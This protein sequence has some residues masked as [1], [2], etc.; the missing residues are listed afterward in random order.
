MTLPFPLLGDDA[1]VSITGDLSEF[2]L[3]HNGEDLTPEVLNLHKKDPAAYVL[4][5]Y[6]QYRDSIE[7]LVTVL[8]YDISES[9]DTKILPDD[10]EQRKFEKAIKNVLEKLMKDKENNHG[11]K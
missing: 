5:N 3:L 2:T 11:V 10:P 4:D 7:K 1:S 9:Q 8:D 6:P